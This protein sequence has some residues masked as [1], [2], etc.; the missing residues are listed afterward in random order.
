MVADIITIT[1]SRARERH[2]RP[3]PLPGS[4]HRKDGTGVNAW[5]FENLPDYAFPRLRALLGATTPA[6][7]GLPLQIGEPKHG[8]PD[9]VRPI[10]DREIE[11]FGRYPPNEGTPA[12]QTAVRQWLGRRYH[13]PQEAIEQEIG[14]VPVNGT[15]EGLFLIAQA[16]TPD[17]KHGRTP[18]ILLPN[19]FYQCY[20]AAAAA[21]GAET[22]YVNADRENGFLPRF[23]RLNPDLLRRTAAV[24]MCS[25][26]NPQGAVADR[27]YWQSL[28]ALAVEHDFA[29]IADECYSEIY[30][31]TPPTGIL[32]AAFAADSPVPSARALDHVVAFNSLSKR[33]NL[34]GLR[35][36]FAAGGKR[37][38]DRFALI[39][40]YGGAPSPLPVY[41]VA[42]AAWA[43]E[44]H[45]EASRTLY[46][47][48][49]EAARRALGDHPGFRL[50]KGGFFLWLDVSSSGRN[51]EQAAIDLWQR[52]GIMVL[53]GAYLARTVDGIN[54]GQDYIRI[55]LVHPAPDLEQSLITVNQILS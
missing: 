48:K 4:I 36:G 21:V 42:A 35:S 41:A 43:D 20:A 5:R 7:E 31:Q 23:D 44:T 1:P 54:P 33:S 13:I 38:I 15:R 53:P 37:L 40:R 19:P 29:V 52:A 32:E 17:R 50:P 51:G 22:V 24:Y 3:V 16:V 39:R 10:L 25:P 14:L 11:D 49:F 18:A 2:G 28:L 9:F 55:A 12:F 46:R 30:G 8:I 47:Q 45:V 34:P 6:S 27:S 26:A